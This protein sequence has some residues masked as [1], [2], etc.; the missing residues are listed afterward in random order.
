VQRSKVKSVDL[1]S[2]GEDKKQEVNWFLRSIVQP[3]PAPYKK[4]EGVLL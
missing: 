3:L 1:S 2:N 4:P